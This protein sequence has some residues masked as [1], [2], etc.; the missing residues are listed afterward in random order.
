MG[1]LNEGD[2]VSITEECKALLPSGCPSV[3]PCFD[4]TTGILFIDLEG[5]LDKW[6]ISK[7]NR[8]PGSFLT[9]AN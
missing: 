4:G 2:C 1:A 5:V 3:P 7:T 9:V 6:Q 8:N